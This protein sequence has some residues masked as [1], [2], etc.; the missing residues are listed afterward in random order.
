MKNITMLVQSEPMFA[1][2]VIEI[3]IA[4]GATSA[5]IPDQ[6]QLRNQGNELCVI[7]SIRLITAKV[8][9]NASQLGTAV[10]PKVDLAKLSLLLYADGWQK[11]HLIPLLT[12]NDV[13]DSDSTAATTIPFVKEKTMLADWANIDW[14]KSSLIFSNGTSASQASACVLQVEYQKFLINQDGTQTLLK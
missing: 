8:L 2:E 6:P 10:T 12:L 11:G 14:N 9:S 7:K 5:V 3:P 13:N 4:N 1:S